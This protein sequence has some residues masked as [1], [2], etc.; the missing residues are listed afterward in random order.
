MS[1]R[2]ELVSSTLNAFKVYDLGQPYF[3][4]MPVHPE[5]PPFSMVVYRYHDYTR[6]LFEKV[7]PGFQRLDGACDYK[8]AFRDTY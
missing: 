2:D 7:A 1:M 6:H 5:D 8:H 4:G 3:N